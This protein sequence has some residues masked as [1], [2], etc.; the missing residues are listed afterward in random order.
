MNLSLPRDILQEIESATVWSKGLSSG[1]PCSLCHQK[2]VSTCKTP[3]GRLCVSCVGSALKDEAETERLDL[4]LVAQFKEAL[5]YSG[6][7]RWRLTVLWRFKEVLQLTSKR[8]PSDTDNLMV[9]LVRNLG[10]MPPHPLARLVRRAAVDA[11]VALGETIL[12]LLLKMC[13]P[14]PWQFYSNIVRAAGLI[15][16][17]HKEV[18][19]LLN[20]AVQDPNPEIRGRVIGT[21]YKY[22][23]PWVKEML[24][25][26]ARRDPHPA[27]RD[28][29]TNVLVDNWKSD[30]SSRQLDLLPK[31]AA[32]PE[33]INK[34]PLSKRPKTLKQ[35]EMGKIVD[36]YYN[37][38]ILKK[39]YNRY[40]QPFFNESAN[41]LKK[42][43]LTAAFALVY[44][45]KESFQKLLSS[46][47]EDVSKILNILVWEGGKH[48]VKKFEKM[49][50]SEI[51]PKDANKYYSGNPINNSYLLFQVSSIYNYRGYE[52]YFYLSDD[53]RKL[54]KQYL[55]L[56]KEANLIPLETIKKT[57]FVYEDNDR[58]VRQ[59]KLWYSYIK[60]G[61]LRFSKSG[62]KVLKTSI[63]Q[64]AKYGDIKEFYDS[65]GLEYLR[66]PL[67]IDFLRHAP[68]IKNIDSSPQSLKQLWDGFFSGSDFNR[69]R[70]AELL[71]HVKGGYYYDPQRETRTRTSLFNLLKTIPASQWVSIENVIKYCACR[72][73]YLEAVDKSDYSL[74]FNKEYTTKYHPSYEKVRIS[75]GPYQDVVTAPLIK[76][77]MFLLAGFGMVD[78]AYNLPQNDLFQEKTNEYLSVF[79]GL[80]YIRLTKLGAYISGLTEKYEVKFE[81]EKANIILDER[82]LIINIEGKDILKTLALERIADKIADNHYRVDY[83]SFLK[84]CYSKKDITQKV[85]FF[86]DE[87]SSK[88]PEVWQDFLDDILKKINPLTPEKTMA[89][90]KL[91]PDQ[92]LISLVAK[93]EILRKHIFK[94]EDYRIVIEASNVKKVKK[95]LGEFG[96][97]IDN[98]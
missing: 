60:Q 55:P 6:S 62:D 79:D 23:F 73:V 13:A 50:K 69:Y 58:V 14:S 25:T 48:D 4:W 42:A 85:K 44:S 52:Y 80:Q 2:G 35:K 57:D 11:C 19:A 77:A 24:Q 61:N 41:N 26:L 40:L 21:I 84:E 72:D 71:Y 16:P 82:R 53:L 76:A 46:L 91:T 3:M 54:F 38:D 8:S 39:I 81:E 1:T 70:L 31:T 43:D 98:I 66:T 96:Y 36:R 94:A 63:S 95:R 97:F 59:I 67:I 15:A 87:I 20:K 68:Q 33:L 93:D 10:Y 51:I 5:S 75:E 89:V 78:I 28:T 32:K 74:Y 12:P 9:Q 30:Q 86:K 49:F 27:I 34:P 88:P 47:P 56:P 7:F 17:E 29:A 18:R 83:N 92:E 45:D 90:Y 37:A 65:N 22:K 64:M